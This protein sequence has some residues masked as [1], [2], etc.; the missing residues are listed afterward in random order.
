[1]SISINT[2]FTQQKQECYICLD[3]NDTFN[4]FCSCSC[5]CCFECFYKVI[6]VIDKSY[7]CDCCIEERFKNVDN[8]ILSLKCPICRKV[9]YDKF[10]EDT[11]NRLKIPLKNILHLTNEY[12]YNLKQKSRNIPRYIVEDDEEFSDTSSLT[13]SDDEEVEELPLFSP[14]HRDDLINRMLEMGLRHTLDFS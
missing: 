7:M 13:D 3:E 8:M 10:D 2:N 6:Q 12:V 11:I 5:K 4:K 9:F 1:M 14:P